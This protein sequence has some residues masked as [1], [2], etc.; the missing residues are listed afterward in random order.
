VTV[1]AGYAVAVAC[2]VL[3]LQQLAVASADKVGNPVRAKFDYQLLCQGCHTPDGSGATGVPQLRG[4]LGYFLGSEEGRAYLV[5][6]PGS[7]NA[8]LTDARLAEVLNWM[9]LA[10]G[11]DSLPAQWRAYAAEE[12]ARYRAEPL[13]EVEEHRLKL[14]HELG[15]DVR[16]LR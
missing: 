15:P 11:E 1:G 16:P 8:A 3:S 7:A 5:R 6:V 9:L 2:A 4:V 10:F 13:F 12:V 14:L